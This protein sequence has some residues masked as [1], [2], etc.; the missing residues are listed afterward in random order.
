LEIERGS[1]MGNLLR[2]SDRCGRNDPCDQPK[3]GDRLHRGGPR[4]GD[5]LA[6]G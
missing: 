6:S 2:E 5:V 4:K 1:T 3:E